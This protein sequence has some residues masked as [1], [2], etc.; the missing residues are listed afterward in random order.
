MIFNV[1]SGILYYLETSKTF[2]IEGV[3]NEIR[4]M[5]IQRNELA[6]YVHEKLDLPPMIRKS[7]MCKHCY[8]QTACFAYHKL[9]EDGTGETSGLNDT[10]EE[11]VNHLKPQH[12]QFFRKWDNLL[13]LEERDT[14][15]FRRE[16]W[17]MLSHERESLGRCF[18]NVV[19]EPGSECE[20]SQ[21][22]KIN[23]FQYSFVKHKQIPGFSFT[24]SQLTTGEPI[25]ISDEKGHFALANGYVTNVRPTRITVAVD[26][27]L[28]NRRK[29]PSFDPETNQVF[30]GDD[31]TLLPRSS[32]VDDKAATLF[33]IDKDEYS[34][35]MATAR[36]NLIRIMEKDLFRARE[37]RQ[38]I[39]DDS[40]PT[41]KHT[42]TAY[43]LSGPASQQDLNIDQRRAIDKVMS[44]KDYA[45]VLGM[46][47]TGKTTT[48]AHIIRALVSQNKS[49]LLTS[50]THTA[51]DNIL[52]KIKDDGIPI[53]RL[54]SVARVCTR[55]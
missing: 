15:K 53:L 20:N 25:V 49:V 8:A 34:N 35:G 24:E 18:A 47:G 9:V 3:R 37:L 32:P 27:K 2:R 30:I 19:V 40:P 12:Q 10:F 52:L 43:I 44:A 14:M 54:G 23:R 7:H 46:P 29:A 17:T 45:L 16:L 33:R 22:S 1:T 39:I 4:H 31:L 42:S 11:A 50:Y 6:C 38:L 5:I 21:T 41:F 36:N 13:T 28:L 51:V 55:R 48:I 26:R